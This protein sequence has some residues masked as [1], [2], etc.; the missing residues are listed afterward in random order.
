MHANVTYLLKWLIVNAQSSPMYVMYS[1]ESVCV[2]VF[3]CVSV[4]AWAVAIDLIY[5][6]VNLINNDAYGAIMN[7][8]FVK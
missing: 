8:T 3:V 6:R 1:N 7:F 5:V 2:C 4:G